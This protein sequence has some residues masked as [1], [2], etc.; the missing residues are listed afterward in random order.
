MYSTTHAH[1]SSLKPYSHGN[2][3]SMPDSAESVAVRTR[4]CL[5]PSTQSEICQWLNIRFFCN[6]A[7]S[8]LSSLVHL[9]S[10]SANA[11]GGPIGL[12]SP[13]FRYHYAA[14]VSLLYAPLDQASRFR[15]TKTDIIRMYENTVSAH[16]DDTNSVSSFQGALAR[17]AATRHTYGSH[18][19]FSESVLTREPSVF[20][21]R[22][23]SYFLAER[24]LAT[25]ADIVKVLQAL[26]WGVKEALAKHGFGE[27]SLAAAASPAVVAAATADPTADATAAGMRFRDV[28]VSEDHY[29]QQMCAGLKALIEEA[30]DS[31]WSPQDR[32]QV[33]DQFFFHGYLAS[34]IYCLIERVEEKK[35]DHTISDDHKM[36]LK[37]L[38]DNTHHN[39]VAFSRYDSVTDTFVEVFQPLSP[40]GAP[41]GT[42]PISFSDC[43]LEK[44]DYTSYV[45]NFHTVFA[46]RLA[47][48][49]AARPAAAGAARLPA[50]NRDTAMR[51]RL[52]R[53]RND[54]D[55]PW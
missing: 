43:Y 45:T 16:M 40:Q 51:A 55:E 6:A 1:L 38:R 26:R 8:H 23:F 17:L 47:A 36:R 42:S 3:P 28:P 4:N 25:G 49:E 29:L 30:P 2:S 37:T 39:S 15:L 44:K 53:E 22:N 14:A 24:K 34:S 18:V 33:C 27:P 32:R 54:L 35:E 21:A 11:S 7:S 41:D 13:N 46:A 20:E 9:A 12:E 31:V 10:H 19:K 5:C 50:S 48:T 52:E